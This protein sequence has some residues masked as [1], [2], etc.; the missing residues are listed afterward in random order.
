MFKDEGDISDGVNNNGEINN[1]S[2]NKVPEILLSVSNI[3]ISF[4]QYSKGLRKIVLN[5]VEDLDLD[6]CEGEVVAILGSSGSGKSLLAHA[7]LGILPGNSVLKGEMKYNG[8]LL[9][10]KL[11]EELR[12]SEIAL[13]PQS[14]DF[15]DP[16]MRIGDQIIGDVEDEK[17]KEEKR[18]EMIR[19]FENYNLG[20][21]TV[22]LYPFQLSGG[23]ARKVL[24]ST[25]LVSDPKLIIADE[26]TPGLDEKS[27]NET[28][29][30]LK[31]MANE[32]RG[33][34]LITHDIRVAVSV[35][36]KIAIFYSGYLI[37]LNETKNFTKN[38]DKLLHPYT[39]ALYK[40][41]PQNGFQLFEGSQPVSMEIKD[42]CIYYDRCNQSIKECKYSNPELMEIGNGMKVR[43][44]RLG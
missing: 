24:F 28:L 5:V 22:D 1:K 27:L 18:E 31:I 36:D 21:D 8:Q 37:E 20:E 13:I 15:L 26:P 3:F 40:S 29:N 25:A 39:R 14:V 10:Q 35:A 44:H 30:Y 43:C 2:I 4:S 32:G 34:V 33:V 19:V 42:Q 9:D 17:E 16:L 38:G 7:I 12:G 11:K 23:M 6:V 41:L